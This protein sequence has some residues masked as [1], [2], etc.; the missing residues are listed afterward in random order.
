MVAYACGKVAA[1]TMARVSASAWRE[2][3]REAEAEV[4]VILAS[5]CSRG[6]PRPDRWACGQR[7][8][9]TA[10]PRGSNGLW[11]VGH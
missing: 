1:A 2:Q 4:E 11:L 7:M 9:A 8:D 3:E 6:T 10:H 5:W